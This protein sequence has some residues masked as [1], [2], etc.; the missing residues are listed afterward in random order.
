MQPFIVKESIYTTTIFIDI[1]YLTL[2]IKKKELS[3]V[4]IS[5]VATC[6]P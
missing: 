3:I 6:T 1:V 4:P 2:N 5:I